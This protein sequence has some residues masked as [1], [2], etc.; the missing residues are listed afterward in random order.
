MEEGFSFLGTNGSQLREPMNRGIITS[1]LTWFMV[2]NPVKLGTSIDCKRLLTGHGQ[3]TADHAG[4][5]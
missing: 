3:M 4:F 1:W 5:V 2:C